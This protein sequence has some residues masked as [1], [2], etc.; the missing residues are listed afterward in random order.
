M[1]NE[2]L[3]EIGTE[4]IPAGFLSKA[5]VD[6]EDIIRKSLTEKHIA[7]E[8]IRCLATPRRLFL[9]IAD[10]AQ[11]Q[12]DQT[13]EKLGPA[14][15][16][17][18]DENGQPTKAA[19]GFARGQGLDVSQLET[20]TTE[21]GEYLGARK[22]IAGQRTNELLPDI[23]KDFMLGKLRSAFRPSRALDSGSLRRQCDSPED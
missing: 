1:S 22:T 17:A 8:G 4:E 21:K 16:A 9:C 10:L 3:F 12:E 11:K 5:V 2:L 20:I 18:F 23:L 7:F 14:K 19:V 6:M 13:I 15:K